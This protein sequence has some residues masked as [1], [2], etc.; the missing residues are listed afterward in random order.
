MPARLKIKD[1]QTAVDIYYK[2]SELGTSEITQLFD[3]SK[4]TATRLKNMVK[5]VQ[6]EEGVM[7]LSD[8]TVNTKCAYKAWHINIGDLE[9]RLIRYKKIL[10]GGITA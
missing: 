4:S 2:H 6:K 1:I 9:R 10:K 5:A 7:T 8:T 3:C